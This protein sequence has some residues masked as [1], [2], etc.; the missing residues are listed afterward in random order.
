LVDLK[1]GP[2]NVSPKVIESIPLGRFVLEH[3]K[4]G[5]VYGIRLIYP[6]EIPFNIYRQ[7]VLLFG[8][9]IGEHVPDQFKV[10]LSPIDILGKLKAIHCE[11]NFGWYPYSGKIFNQIINHLKQVFS[12]IR[13]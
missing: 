6:P 8:N 9:T 13:L 12:G 11:I 2:L 10:Q 4:E 1:T 7:L 3:F 5:D